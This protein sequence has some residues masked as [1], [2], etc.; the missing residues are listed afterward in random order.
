M[1]DADYYGVLGVPRGASKDEIKHAYRRLAKKYHPDLNKDNPKVAEE[2]FKQLSEAYEVLCDDDKRKIYD[3]FGADGLKQQ[4]WGGQG[5]DWS[6]FTHAEDVED[7]FGADFFQSVF[8]RSGGLGGTL[9]EDFFGG[10]TVGRRRGPAPGRDAR[11][12]LEVALEDV[13][14]GGRKEV[15]VQ[16][17][18]TCPA[19]RGTG[20]EGERL[21]TCPTC[22]G[23]GQMS[24]SQRQ[25]YSQ[26]ITI[27]T[28]PK[29][30]GRGQWP[31]RPCRRCSGQ[32]RIEERRTIAVEIPEGVPDGVQLRIPGRGLAGDAGA[33]PGDLYVAIHV[34]PHHR[35]VRDGDDLVL[36]LPISFA[37]AALGTEVEVPTMEGTTRLRVPAG[38][39]THTTLRLRGKGLPRFQGHGR[40]DQL[41]RVSV[42]T[43]TRLSAEERRL[44]EQ[45][46]RLRGDDGG[47]RGP[48]DRFRSP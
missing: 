22:G 7:I 32:G 9:F 37:D 43:P 46:R 33:P 48:F 13:A 17:P 29:C 30:N 25:G 34:R 14:R 24:S 18:M 42:I 16:Y 20:A 28:C 10:G 8:G 4:V 44:L 23:R 31:E 36:E 19:C 35:F 47:S 45:L 38:V 3:Q 6:R 11:V 1:G 21:V 41:V 12:D 40:G 27:T 39:Q 5:F 2:K 26:F 15:T